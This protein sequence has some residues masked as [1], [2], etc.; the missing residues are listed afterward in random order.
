MGREVT[1]TRP[2]LANLQAGVDK[3][4]SCVDA[5]GEKPHLSNIIFAWSSDLSVIKTFG[6][7]DPVSLCP[8]CFDDGHVNQRTLCFLAKM[9]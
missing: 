9:A 1:I 8:K 4:L 5:D 7:Y 6:T 3:F 2:R